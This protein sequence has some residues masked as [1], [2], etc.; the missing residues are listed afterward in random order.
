MNTQPKTYNINSNI[1]H[2]KI[3]IVNI[4]DKP[5]TCNLA[6][7]LS[8]AKNKNTDLI[9][10]AIAGDVSVCKLMN[11]D[12]WLYEKNK[13]EKL[14]KKNQKQIKTKEIYLTPNIDDHDLNTK[15]NQAIRFLTA[16]NQVKVTLQ[17]KGRE[18]TYF[19]KGE[20]IIYKFI[21]SVISTQGKLH[22]LPESNADKIIAMIKPN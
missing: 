21:D 5:I 19:D 17:F 7:A 6:Q 8:L 20:V 3:K 4:D 9:E 13:K 1:K 2:N 22:K 16:N 14:I 10:V 18:R 11:Y 15:I 12:K